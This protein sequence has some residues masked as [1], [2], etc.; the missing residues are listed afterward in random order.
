M[1]SGATERSG[2]AHIGAKISPDGRHVVF[3]G[4]TWNSYKDPKVRTI[5]GGLYAAPPFD[6]WVAPID[7]QTLRAGKPR[8]IASLRGRTGCAG[9]DHCYTWKDNR[10]LYVNIPSLKGLYEVDIDTGSI[11][12]RV[13]AINS[14]PRQIMV[15]PS[16]RALIS[17]QPD[18]C[19]WISMTLSADGREPTLG[20]PFTVRGCQSTVSALD[21]VMVWRSLGGSFPAVKLDRRPPKKKRGRVRASKTSPLTEMQKQLPEERHCTYFPMLSRDGTLLAFGASFTDKRNRNHSLGDFEIFVVP[22]DPATAA[23]KGKPVRYSW[24]T[25]AMHAGRRGGHANDDSLVRTP[26]S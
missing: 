2:Y 10:T 19:R 24:N 22:V 12:R 17:S 21:T 23:P 6:T 9:E 25:H 13:I 1:I 18:S 4:K 16:G 14:K 26:A 7:P 15:A 5:Y 20:P 3:A 8:E 11:G